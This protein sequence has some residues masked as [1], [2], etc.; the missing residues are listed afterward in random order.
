MNLRMSRPVEVTPN[1]RHGHGNVEREEH[2][3]QRVDLAGEM[4]I[5]ILVG[6]GYN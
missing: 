3:K 6:Q 4:Q 1:V 5:F 2:F